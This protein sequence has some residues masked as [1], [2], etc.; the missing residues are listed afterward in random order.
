MVGGVGMIGGGGGRG[1]GRGYLVFFDKVDEGCSF[2]FDWL[3]LEVVEGDDEVEEVGLAKVRRRLLLEM[4]TR[5]SH[6]L[7]IESG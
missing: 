5:Q 6:R 7:A 3:S 4:R 2:D 1:G